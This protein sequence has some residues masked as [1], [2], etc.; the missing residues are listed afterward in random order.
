[1]P[2]LKNH[3]CS[4]RWLEAPGTIAWSRTASASSLTTSRP[5]P[6]CAAFHRLRSV[7]YMANPSWC[8]AT[9]TTNWAPAR[10][11]RLA[12]STGSNADPVNRGMKSL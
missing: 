8:S 4:A 9:G 10:R 6:I 7:A 5:G 12:H 1:M 3:Q 11:K 2:P